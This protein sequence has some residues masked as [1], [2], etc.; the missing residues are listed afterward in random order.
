MRILAAALATCLVICGIS[1]T[2]AMGIAHPEVYNACKSTIDV[3]LFMESDDHMP[4]FV[5]ILL[6][7]LFI[8]S[9]PVSSPFK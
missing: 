5:A 3:T 7:A 6:L 1:R 9:P 4:D 2:D 8:H